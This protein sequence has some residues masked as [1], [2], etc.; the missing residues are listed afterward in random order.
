MQK[1]Q[2]LNIEL[3]RF[4]FTIGVAV[5]HFGYYN[6]FYIAVDFFFILSGFLLCFTIEKNESGCEIF[7]NKIKRIYPHYIF[8]FLLMLGWNIYVRI[9]AN[10]KLNLLFWTDSILE[11]LSLQLLA[12]SSNIINGITWYISAMLLIFPILIFSLKRNKKCFVSFY[13]P[14]IAICIY[15]FFESN[16]AH[17][18]FGFVWLGHVNG[19]LVRGIA[20]MCTGTFLYY[21]HLNLTDS[22]R[23]CVQNK[24]AFVELVIVSFVVY[25]SI[26]NRQ[27]K[28]DFIEI[29]LLAILV[30]LSFNETG[31][32]FKISDNKFCKFL[33]KISYEIYLNQLFIICVVKTLW[34]SNEN[35]TM[36]TI[37]YVVIL[38]LFSACTQK[39][40]D[41]IKSNTSIANLKVKHFFQHC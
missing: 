27:T 16:W 2:C 22:I 14:V 30:L 39:I 1:K 41:L 28:F 24:I 26:F 21:V 23:Q 35:N 33:G 36:R 31:F 19:G 5:M 37:V 32:I 6:G 9:I 12:P 11:G 17:I 25:F 18:D 8:S 15:S 29:I 13:A 34:P 20:G 7:L 3:W 38:I 4:I 10:C 40:I